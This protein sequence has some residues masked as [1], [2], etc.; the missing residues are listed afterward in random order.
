MPHTLPDATHDD[1]RRESEMSDGVPTAA[2]DRLSRHYERQLWLERAAVGTA[3]ELLAPAG[4]ERILDVATGTGEVLRQLARRA[5]RPRE[6]VGI[7]T[8]AAMLARVGV[9]PDGWSVRV[10]DA[11]RLPFGDGEFD[12]AGAAYALHVL[13][14]DDLPTALDEL[15]R[16]L[17]AG[18]RLVTVTPAIPDRGPARPLARALDRIAARDPERYGGLRALDPRPALLRAGFVIDD[19]RWRLRGYPSLCVLTRR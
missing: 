11:R 19:A 6:V 12:A 10:G 8:S 7:D 5:E 14:D 15:A 16:V 9:L 1:E 2:W 4:D 18:G 3:V 13:A 17:R